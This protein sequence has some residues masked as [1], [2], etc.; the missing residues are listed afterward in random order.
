M[1]PPVRAGTQSQLIRAYHASRKQ[2]ARVASWL[3]AG[4]DGFWLGVMHPELLAKLN[5]S[6]YN[7]PDA[8]GASGKAGYADEEWVLHGLHEWER[9]AIERHFPAGGRVIVTGAGGGREVLALLESGYDAV[10]LEPHAGLVDDGNRILGAK[11]FPGRLRTAPRE[12]FPPVEG[13]WG[14]LVVGWG[15][16]MHI[17]GHEERLRFLRGAADR[18]APGA[19]ILISALLRS[20]GFARH[21]RRVARIGTAIRRLQG[22]APVEFGDAVATFFAHRFSREELEAEL[23]QAGFEPSHFAPQPYGHWVGLR[24][25]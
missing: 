16:Y 22:A 2:R 9:E 7:G 18:L 19:P 21:D 12:G 5:D 8:L 1:R 24:R 25:Q 10:G 11:G 15:A 17:S 20:P 3:Y 4:T 6:F 23:E 13:A 14:G